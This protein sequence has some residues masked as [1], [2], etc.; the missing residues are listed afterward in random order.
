MALRW[1]DSA[2][3]SVDNHYRYVGGRKPWP[4]FLKTRER[5]HTAFS[6]IQVLET[7]VEAADINF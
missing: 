1:K 5:S 7:A 6:V 2:P 3:L 4:E